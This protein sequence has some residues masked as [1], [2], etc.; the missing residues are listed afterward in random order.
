MMVSVGRSVPRPIVLVTLHTVSGT[1]PSHRVTF[2]VS[3]ACEWSI[4]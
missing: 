1:A 4:V 3:R 2:P